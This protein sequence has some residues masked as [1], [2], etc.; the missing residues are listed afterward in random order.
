MVRP[1]LIACLAAVAAVFIAAAALDGAAAQISL[2]PALAK[3]TPAGPA[4]AKGAI[5]WSHG[6]SIDAEDSLAPTPDYIAAMRKAGWDTFRLNR[7]RVSDQFPTSSRALAADAGELKRR[8]YRRV[9]LA[10]QSFGAFISL[11]AAARSDAIDA[12][13]ATAPAA[14]G[15]FQDSY[16]TFRL[17]ATKLYDLLREVRHARV[18]LAFFHGDDFDPGGRGEVS[19][20]ILTDR[21]LPHLVIDQPAGLVTHWAANTPA[22]TERF[23]GCLSAFAEDDGARGD[24][25]CGQLTRMAPAIASAP[26]APASADRRAPAEQGPVHGASGPAGGGRRTGEATPNQG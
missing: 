14:Y 5:I 18:A 22:F 2:V 4:R 3:D 17:N 12:V 21:G 23:A 11:I 16:D 25:D 9:V 20:E 19:D 6:R 24:L 7:M 8:G 15:N 13:I 1:R 26:V 10:G